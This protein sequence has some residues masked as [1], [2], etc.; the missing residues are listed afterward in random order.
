MK[1]IHFADLHLGVEAYGRADPETGLSTRLVD[2][3]RSFDEM[4]KFAID[5]KAD[6]ML[7][8]GDAYKSRE[9]SQ[10]QQ[11]E[12]AKRIRRL[13]LNNIP[14]FLLIGNHDLPNAVGRATATEIF[15]TLAVENVY[16]SSK[17]GIYS[18]PTASGNIQIVSLPWLRRSS[19]LAMLGKEDGRALNFNQINDRLQEI[20]TGLIAENAAK[21]DPKLPAILSA[22]VW[23]LNARTGSEKHMTIGHEHMLLA[24]NVAHPSFD[25]VALGHIHR[26]QVLHDRPPVVYSG[27]LNRLDFGDEDDEKGFY[28]IDIETENRTGKRSVSYQFHPVSGRR[29]VTINVNI[30]PDDLDP[31]ATALKAIHEQTDKARDSIVRLNLNVPSANAGQLRDNEIRQALSDAHYFTIARDIK[32]DTRLRLGNISAEEMTPIDALQKWLET[33]TVPQEKADTLIE[34]GQRLMQDEE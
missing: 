31:S 6:L 34:Y 25:Y 4:V 9:P 16:V 19:L 18:I 28:V 3:L 27:S 8:C 24:G 23:V 26:H 7:F 11:R 29:F 10:T 33:K 20:L 14:I 5:N 17:P 22:H 21:L 1:I 15:D 30:A 2:F 12:F 32:K 13:S